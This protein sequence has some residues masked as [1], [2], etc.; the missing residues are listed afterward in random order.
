[1]KIS[2][3]ILLSELLSTIIEVYQ[4]AMIRNRPSIKKAQRLKKCHTNIVATWNKKHNPH[5][6][7]GPD[8]GNLNFKVCKK[9]GSRFYISL[10]IN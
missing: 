1:M 9:G 6:D 2:K 8:C 5:P 3:K 4:H 10:Q 7:S